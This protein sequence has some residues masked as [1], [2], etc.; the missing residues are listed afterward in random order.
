MYIQSEWTYD[1]FHKNAKVNYRIYN[2]GGLFS[3]TTSTATPLGPALLQEFSNIKNV[4]RFYN[5][6]RLIATGSDYFNDD[7]LFADDNF[8]EMFSFPLR[9]GDTA[10]A[11]KENNSIVLSHAAAQN[12]LVMKIL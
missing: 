9:F 5:T 3:G 8:F 12:I 1:K 2:G 6:E 4:V 7:I 10:S 11:L